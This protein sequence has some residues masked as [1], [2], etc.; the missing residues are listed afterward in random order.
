[1]YSGMIRLEKRPCWVGIVWT[2]SCTQLARW[3]GLGGIFRF[4]VCFGWESRVGGFI[5]RLEEIE[6]EIRTVSLTIHP[7]Y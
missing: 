5:R 4:T 3:Y 7:R 2:V 1:M 6:E